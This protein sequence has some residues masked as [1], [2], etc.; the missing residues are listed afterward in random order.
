MSGPTPGPWYASVNLRGMKCTSP[1]IDID[2]A[3]NSNVA[4]AHHEA[5]DRPE[6]ET[7]AN[8]RLIAAAPDLLAALQALLNRQSQLCMDENH[9]YDHYAAWE[10][11][12][13]AARAAIAKAVQ[14]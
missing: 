14:P 4:L 11:S 7:R 3:D 10:A 5:S 8:A 12:Q 6:S 2:A 13:E 1:G 9:R